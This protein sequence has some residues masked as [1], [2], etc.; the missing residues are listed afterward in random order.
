M[1]AKSLRAAMKEKAKRLAGS[2]SGKVDSSTFTPAENLNA[3]AKKG[4]R[5]ISRRAFKVGGKVEGADNETRA[6][7]SKRTPG[8]KIG[9]ANTDQK[10]ANAERDGKKHVG[11]FKKG[12]RTGKADGGEMLSSPRPMARPANFD[13]IVQNAKDKKIQDMLDAAERGAAREHQDYI[14]GKQMKKGGRAKARMCGAAPKKLKVA[15][16]IRSQLSLPTL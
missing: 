7:R 5:P 3:E 2:S 13:E 8:G 1:D 9:L 11:G 12:G 6:D 10:A 16:P 4:M 14:D 15:K